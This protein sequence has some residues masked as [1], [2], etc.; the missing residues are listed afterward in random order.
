MKVLKEGTLMR[1]RF[2]FGCCKVCSCEVEIMHGDPCVTKFEVL[3]RDNGE[4]ASKRVGWICPTCS[5][6]NEIRDNSRCR[7]LTSRERADAL[8]FV[9]DWYDKIHINE[10]CAE[11]DDMPDGIDVTWYVGDGIVDRLEEPLDN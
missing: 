5:E 7:N 6:E 1:R 10:Q 2:Y 4:I 3:R 8:K 9:R 11:Q